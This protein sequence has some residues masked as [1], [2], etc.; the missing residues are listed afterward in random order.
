MFQR[1]RIK[2]DLLEKLYVEISE[3]RRGDGHLVPEE[4]LLEGRAVGREVSRT[5][6]FWLP[7]LSGI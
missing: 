7:D 6:L 4:D 1:F 5:K 2:P 3:G